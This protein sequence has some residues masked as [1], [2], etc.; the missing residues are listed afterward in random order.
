M[1]FIK[2]LYILFSAHGLMDY[3]LY[4]LLVIT[5]SLVGIIE[6]FLLVTFLIVVQCLLHW[7]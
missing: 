4:L 7:Q 2:I 3:F 1:H 5:F 6:V